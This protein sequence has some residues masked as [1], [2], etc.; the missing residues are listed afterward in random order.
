[1]THVTEWGLGLCAGIVDFHE[2]APPEG[3]TST[4]LDVGLRPDTLA[5]TGEKFT[6]A[7]V[8]EGRIQRILSA[9]ANKKIPTCPRCAVLRDEALEGRLP[10]VAR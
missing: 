8:D 1:M 7:D 3:R 9:F 6:D 10:V 5:C 4:L 2:P